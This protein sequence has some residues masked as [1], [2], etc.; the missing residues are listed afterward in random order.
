MVS[1][2]SSQLCNMKDEYSQI[3]NGYN[4]INDKYL[5]AKQQFQT[6]QKELQSLQVHDQALNLKKQDELKKLL[7]QLE[8]LN[9][10]NEITNEKLNK[11]EA[12]TLKWENRYKKCEQKYFNVDI[13]EIHK[14]KAF[15][16]S[17]MLLIS[18]KLKQYI[19]MY[20]EI[21]LDSKFIINLEQREDEDLEKRDLKAILIR[22][23]EARNNKLIRS[24]L[25]NT[26]AMRE[27]YEM[28]LKQNRILEPN[29]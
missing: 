14:R 2:L 27:D 8:H 4:S 13:D 22:I 3:T 20:G 10:E 21:V 11:S 24:K 18:E 1:S 7:Q 23:E 16:E 17:K 9:Y 29:F 15:V 28:A 6:C 5:Q 26:R 19:E 25:R 12:R